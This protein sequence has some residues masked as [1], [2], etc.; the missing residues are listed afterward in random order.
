MTDSSWEDSSFPGPDA[1][2]GPADESLDAGGLA[3][4][5]VSDWLAGEDEGGAEEDGVAEL[6]GAGPGG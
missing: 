5:V 3:G 2:D 6:G 1:F 4:A